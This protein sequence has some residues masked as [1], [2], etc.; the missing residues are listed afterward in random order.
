MDYRY[1]SLIGCLIYLVLLWTVGIEIVGA[2]RDVAAST[3]DEST[4]YASLIRLLVVMFFSPITFSAPA[5]A[6]M[7]HAIRSLGA[8]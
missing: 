4:Q 3:I 8:R 5:I 2:F 6:T 7:Y 1:K